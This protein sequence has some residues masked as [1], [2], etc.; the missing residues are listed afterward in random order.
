MTAMLDFRLR[1]ND[2]WPRHP[3]TPLRVTDHTW[4]SLHWQTLA[5]QGSAAERR[6]RKTPAGC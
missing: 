4:F 1:E 2:G 6:Q 5:E 3:S